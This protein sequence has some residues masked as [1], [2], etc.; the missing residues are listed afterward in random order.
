MRAA[1]RLI[2]YRLGEPMSAI[3]TFG[4]APATWTLP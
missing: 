4:G 1:P 2:G 3:Y